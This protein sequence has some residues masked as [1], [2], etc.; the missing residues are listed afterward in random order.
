MRQILYILMNV[1]TCIA[2]ADPLAYC[3][4]IQKNF[5]TDKR[6]SIEVCTLPESS[7][8]DSFQVVDHANNYRSNYLQSIAR[9]RETAGSGYKMVG[10]RMPDPTHPDPLND[11]PGEGAFREYRDFGF[12]EYSAIDQPRIPLFF[13]H[14]QCDSAHC[15]FL[16]VECAQSQPFQL[17]TI[18]AFSTIDSWRNE[19]DVK[20]RTAINTL[21]NLRQS[22]SVDKSCRQRVSPEIMSEPNFIRSVFFDA[23]SGHAW[24]IRCLKAWKADLIQSS[25]MKIFSQTFKQLDRYESLCKQSES[26]RPL[27]PAVS[28]DVSPFIAGLVRSYR[29][30]GFLAEPVA[31]KDGQS[32]TEIHSLY[33][34]KIITWPWAFPVTDESMSPV[35]DSVNSNFPR[36]YKKIPVIL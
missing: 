3:L 31:V 29:P 5:S 13:Y 34:P 10:C 32:W 17:T 25:Q 12:I 14:Y 15:G 9:S 6:S 1:F 33:Q 21:S 35:Y 27:L 20:N 7:Q 26:P 28:D 4:P 22:A 16:K 36:A 24:A 8:G 2:Y 23:F 18:D 30:D 11:C 19:T